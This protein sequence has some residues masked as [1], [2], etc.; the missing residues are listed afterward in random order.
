VCVCVRV[1]VHVCVCVCER[2]R[3]ETARLLCCSCCAEA[4]THKHSA[5]HG[6]GWVAGHTSTCPTR[7]LICKMHCSCHVPLAA[8]PH[9]QQQATNCVQHT[10]SQHWSSGHTVRLHSSRFILQC[11][12]ICHYQQSS[13]RSE[14]DQGVSHLATRG[15][16]QKMLGVPRCS[17]TFSLSHCVS[18]P[19]LLLPPSLQAR[20]RQAQ[21]GCGL[22]WR[23]CMP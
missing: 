7:F 2:E 21:L 17:R 20:H 1:R 13:G 23:S 3:G 8:C 5:Q 4:H 11:C 19:Q 9:T 18:L 6:S 10:H 16:Q 14:I 15:S 12:L 22:P